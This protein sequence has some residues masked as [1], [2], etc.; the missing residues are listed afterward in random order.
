MEIQEHVCGDHW[1]YHVLEDG[2]KIAVFSDY[3]DA[4]LFIWAK[5]GDGPDDDPLMATLK[6]YRASKMF[7]E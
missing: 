6:R 7:G 1:L 4:E 5:T 3:E 2:Q